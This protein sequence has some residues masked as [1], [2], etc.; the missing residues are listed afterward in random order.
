MSYECK[1][2]KKEI[3]NSEMAGLAIGHLGREVFDKKLGTQGFSKGE[4]SAGLLTGLKIPCPSCSKSDWKS[5]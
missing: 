3:S 2:C 4:F 5:T 1:N